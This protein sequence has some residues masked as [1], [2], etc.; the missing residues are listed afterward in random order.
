MVALGFD[1]DLVEKF[2]KNDITGS[3]LIDLKWD[4][5]KEVC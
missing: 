1:T 2:A 3:I 4:D 5:L